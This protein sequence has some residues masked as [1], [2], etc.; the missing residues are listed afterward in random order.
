MEDLK[1][2]RG[3]IDKIDAQMAALFERRMSVTR[4]VGEYKLA[5]GLPVLDP[6]REREVLEKKTALLQDK[7]LA[8]DVTALFECIMGLSRQQQRTLVK[9]E[10]VS[11]LAGYYEALSHSREPLKH[12]RVLYQGEPGAYAEEAAARFFGEETERNRVETWEDIFLALRAGEADYGVIPIENNSTGSINAAYDLLAKYHAFIVGEQIVRVDHCLMAPKG[13]SLDTLRE[14]R[15]HEQGLIQCG[16]YLKE[17]PDWKRVPMLNTAAAAKFVAEQGD[18]GLAAIGS[19]R[20]AKL[21]GLDILAEKINF[22]AENYTRFVVVSPLMEHRP[23][24]DKI[25]ATFTLPHESGSLHRVMTVFAVHGVNMLK[26]ES[27]PIVGKSWE[28]RFFVDLEGSLSDPRMD[29]VVHE[30]AQ[31]TTEFRFLGGYQSG[32][33]IVLIG[34]MGCGKTTCGKL[35]AEKL[36]WGFVDT[37]ALIEQESGRTIPEIFAKEGEAGFRDW[38]LGVSEELARE[39]RLVIACG[40]GLPTRAD[41]IASLRDGGTVFFLHRDPE[42]I[43]D[44]VSMANRPLGQDGKEAFLERFRQR[45]PIYREWSDHEITSFGS[46]EETVHAILEALE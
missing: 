45:E 9:E 26:L 40:G 28:Y 30:L 44:S 12:P 17:H 5:H 13:A 34:M 11:G 33:N 4:K 7:A 14:V 6:G 25:S 42:K 18:T 23:L 29:G 31:L 41:S 19:P 37:D 38:E 10:N 3:Q 2:L 36:G 43:Y 1:E 39:R 24:E 8:S 15:S 35:L 22:N 27:R 32:K 21:Y 46:P 16:D 20:A